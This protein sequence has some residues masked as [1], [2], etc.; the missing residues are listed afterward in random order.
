M[1]DVFTNRK[2]TYAHYV[3]N[4]WTG[5]F[6]EPINKQRY[7]D[8]AKFTRALYNMDV[9]TFS[10]TYSNYLLR[11]FISISHKN[12]VVTRTKELFETNKL[13]RHTIKNI[14]K[15][16]RDISEARI[17]L[18]DRKKQWYDNHIER[19]RYNAQV[20][21]EIIDILAKPPLKIKS[22]ILSGGTI[23]GCITST[24]LYFLKM[25]EKFPYKIIIPLNLLVTSYPLHDYKR[26]FTKQ[27]L[28][29]KLPLDRIQIIDDK[30]RDLI[31]KIKEELAED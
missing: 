2:M 3:I 17:Q 26:Y 29:H 30:P 12:F 5:L 28:T 25:E 10:L 20:R 27:L 11:N 14:K 23:A 4:P 9:P 7:S 19:M 16:K 1:A 15:K 24:L 18:S 31:N 21:S 22:L 6:Y 13:F 8:I